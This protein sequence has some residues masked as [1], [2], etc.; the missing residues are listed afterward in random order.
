MFIYSVVLSF[1]ALSRSKRKTAADSGVAHSNR[2][3]LARSIWWC[4]FAS[5]IFDTQCLY[6][7]NV[8]LVLIGAANLY[9]AQSLIIFHTLIVLEKW[10][11]RQPSSSVVLNRGDIFTLVCGDEVLRGDG[12]V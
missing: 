7:C 12:F 5:D 2:S 6:R 10:V 8:S 1:E 3:G 4:A 9:W 11:S